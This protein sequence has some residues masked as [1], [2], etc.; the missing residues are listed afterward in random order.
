V[1]LALR[2]PDW[3]L[4]PD[5]EL[6]QVICQ[7][8]EERFQ[9][10]SDALV[11]KARVDPTLFGM[12][13]TMTLAAS[14]GADLV[15]A[16]IGGSRAY[17]FRQGRLQR[18]TQDHTVAQSLADLGLISTDEI[19][20]HGGRHVLTNVI[21]AG[22]GHVHVDLL[23]LRLA[24]GDQ[25]MLCTDGLPDMVSEDA[26][27]KALRESKSAAEACRALVDMAL[28]GGGKDNVTVVV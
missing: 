22:G 11:G 8:M 12:G 7:R 18:L 14:V 3:I 16:H 20:M 6:M 10:V 9:E 13:T 25:L 28:D 21:G 2:T 4:R 26:M 5:D 15:L 27:T 19:P 1:D 17:L 24:D 23:A